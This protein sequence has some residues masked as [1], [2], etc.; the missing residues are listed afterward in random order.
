MTNN[1]QNNQVIEANQVQIMAS[2]V[3]ADSL[4]GPNSIADGGSPS[5]CTPAVEAISTTDNEDAL[6]E[7]HMAL[8]ELRAEL[9]RLQSED[10]GQIAT[11]F[12]RNFY[13]NGSAFT[14]GAY[15]LA[16]E[17]ANIT[18]AAAGAAMLK[19]YND[20][21]NVQEAVLGCL[22]GATVVVP[23]MI[24]LARRNAQENVEFSS[25]NYTS[26]VGQLLALIA[27]PSIGYGVLQE[28]YDLKMN[29]AQHVAAYELGM[30]TLSVPLTILITGV[31]AYFNPEY[32]QIDGGAQRNASQGDN[33]QRPVPVFSQ[34]LNQVARVDE[35]SA[36]S[37]GE[38]QEVLD[39]ESQHPVANRVV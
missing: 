15:L 38:D 39:I 34:S 25:W 21:Y 33:N 4:A 31:I 9:N 11:T 36:I 12:F 37:V 19:P 30:I 10:S 17:A 29:Y 26:I 20:S 5:A 35:V 7:L 8:T 14:L 6:I 16:V 23:P 2:A 32:C 27:L 3:I 24:Y 13:K 28:M 1:T 22:I 18:Y